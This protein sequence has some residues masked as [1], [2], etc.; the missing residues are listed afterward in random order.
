MGRGVS[1][2]RRAARGELVIPLQPPRPSFLPLF[3]FPSVFLLFPFFFFLLLSLLSSSFPYLF[4]LFSFSPSLCPFFLFPFSFFLF[5]F[6]FFLFPFSLFL[7]PLSFFGS[8]ASPSSSASLWGFAGG[9]RSTRK[10]GSARKWA[11]WFEVSGFS[12]SGFWIFGLERVVGEGRVRRRERGG[13]G[14][15]ERGTDTACAVFCCVCAR[16]DH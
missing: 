11:F 4:L 2:P 10:L 16:T 14:R 9:R 13:R 15:G 8:V 3:L 12:G 5:P 1:Q 7:V 6:S